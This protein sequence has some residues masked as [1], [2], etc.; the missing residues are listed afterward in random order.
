MKK[1][2]LLVLLTS[3]SY[4]LF[5]Q[6]L[7]QFPGSSISTTG[8]VNKVAWTSPSNANSSTSTYTYAS[9]ATKGKLTESLRLTN[10][11]FSGIPALATING[12][13]VELYK[14]GA[15]G[16]TVDESIRLMKAASTPTGHAGQI[17]HPR[18]VQSDHPSP[19]K[20]TTP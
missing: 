13:S 9:L 3:L 11:D 2:L 18:P 4:M 14:Q 15:N 5:S 7:P 16:N 20:L 19:V 6:S 1:L 12:I 8:D 17:D 10:F